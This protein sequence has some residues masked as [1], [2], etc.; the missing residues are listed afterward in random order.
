MK[1]FIELTKDVLLIKNSVSDPNKLYEIIKQS[2][3]EQMDYFGPWSD[4]KPW[5]F[6]SK[7]Y[8]ENDERWLNDGGTLSSYFIKET[9]DAFWEAMSYYKNNLLNE[10]YFETWNQSKNFPTSWEELANKEKNK[11]GW[12]INDLLIAETINSHPKKNLSMEYHKDRRM[13][14]T[15]NALFFNYNIYINDD[16]EGGEIQFVDLETAEESTYIDKNGDERKCLM[17][18]DPI[19]YKPEAGDAL[20]FRTDHAHG[21]LPVKGHKFY[22]RYNL[23]T[24][25]NENI[26]KI[27]NEDNYEEL[28][29]EIE[30]DGFANKLWDAKLFGSKETVNTDILNPRTIAMVLKSGNEDLIAKQYRYPYDSSEDYEAIWETDFLYD[31]NERKPAR[32]LEK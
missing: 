11:E 24:P 14:D 12:S 21:V 31:Y 22:V 4:W 6:Y 29:K 18:D 28:L 19:T 26:K 5:G 25:M 16:Y 23:V 15:P 7:I 2:K 8:P 30:K 27:R 1:E 32:L 20:L 13:W 17:V 3:Q 10:E 9:M